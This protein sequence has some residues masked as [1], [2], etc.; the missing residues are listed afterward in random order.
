[1]LK[2]NRENL[3]RALSMAQLCLETKGTIPALAFALFEQKNG[4]LT[5]TGTDLDVTLRTIIEAEGEDGSF[6]VPA[7]ELGRLAGLFE[8]EFVT[9]ELDDKE[10]VIVKCGKARYKLP[11][12]SRDSFPNIEDVKAR[13]F[14]IKGD[15]LKKILDHTVI[16]TSTEASRYALQG[17]LLKTTGGKLIAVA[18]D[19]SRL[20]LMKYPIP[21]SEEVSGLIPRKAVSVLRKALSDDESVAITIAQEAAKFEQEDTVIQTRLLIGTFPNYE[22]VIPKQREH[23]ITLS[24]E[25]LRVLKRGV[26][27][28]TSMNVSGG[29]HIVFSVSRDGLEIQTRDADRGE[30]VET[31]AA[32]C[33]TLN[34]ESVPLA[35]NSTFLT[36]ML[37][38]EPEIQMAFND[39]TSQFL[40]TPTGTRDYE[41]QYVIMPCRI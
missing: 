13:H 22:M 35:F 18:T 19:S 41:Y 10:R 14:L 29:S 12:L 7:R 38:V 24:D 6:G 26:I 16:C 36:D 34:G 9:F 8:G 1:M 28:A 11:A 37:Q 32:Q 20:A 33:P 39:N 4:K 27:T 2:V 15:T 3:S 5:I 25:L 23:S 40:L 21:F 17:V 31:V 30:G